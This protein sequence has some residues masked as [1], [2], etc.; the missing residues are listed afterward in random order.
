MSA[1]N[2]F[3]S[4]KGRQTC[5]RGE[6]RGRTVGRGGFCHQK[7][8]SYGPVD[9]PRCRCEGHLLRVAVEEQH[10]VGVPVVLHDHV[11]GM[12]AVKG[13]FWDRGPVDGKHAW[14]EKERD[15]LGCNAR[16]F[17]FP[18]ASRTPCLPLHIPS[19]VLQFVFAEP[20]EVL[21]WYP[22][23]DLKELLAQSQSPESRVEDDCP[24]VPSDDPEGK[25]GI[26]RDL[27][28][29]LCV[30]GLCVGSW[31]I[32]WDLISG[33][34]WLYPDPES[35]LCLEFCLESDKDKLAGED[36]LKVRENQ[37]KNDDKDKG[38]GQLIALGSHKR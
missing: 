24:A 37:K 35:V 3:F 8:H 11:I 10:R 31:D 16:R 7:R 29:I 15:E 25:D 27:H 18:T 23:P 30:V 28:L 34:I 6:V 13:Q 32:H 12:G 1:S 33:H 5:D 9:N 4:V 2:S 14:K 36:G 38:Q 22:C 21:R 20:E 19:E 17:C 26:V